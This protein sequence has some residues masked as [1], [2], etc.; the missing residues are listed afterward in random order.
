MKQD[1]IGWKNAKWNGHW[2]I[3]EENRDNGNKLQIKF[4]EIIM[5]ESF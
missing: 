5:G 4:G 2:N 3:I 1:K